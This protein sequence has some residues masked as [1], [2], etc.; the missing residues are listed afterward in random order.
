MKQKI[1]DYIKANPGCRKRE[2]AHSLGVWQC[3]GE[4]LRTVADMEN[5]GIIHSES[6]SDP[7]QM[8]FYLKYFIKTP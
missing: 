6:Y 4:F 2:I 8:E 3:N 1:L 7:A 5:A